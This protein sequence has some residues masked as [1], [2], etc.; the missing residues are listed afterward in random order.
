[1]QGIKTSTA[2]T[3]SRFAEVELFAALLLTDERGDRVV[4]CAVFCNSIIVSVWSGN[5][6]Q[7]EFVA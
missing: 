7:Q 6:F 5:C 2:E 4:I 3:P 1:M